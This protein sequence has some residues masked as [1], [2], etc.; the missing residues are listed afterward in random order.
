MLAGQMFPGRRVAASAR[1]HVLDG[2]QRMAAAILPAIDAAVAEGL[3]T[4]A[5]AK[6]IRDVAGARIRHLNRTLGW[7]IAAETDAP[8]TRGGGWAFS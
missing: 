4:R 1:R 2:L 8:I 6:P 3:V 7:S 5:E